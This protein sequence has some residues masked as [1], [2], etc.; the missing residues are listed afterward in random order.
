MAIVGTHQPYAAVPS[1]AATGASVDAAATAAAY[2]VL[3]GLFPNRANQYQAPYDEGLAKIPDG[4]A[5]TRG[6]AIGKDVA[7]RILA[8]RANDGRAVQLPAYVPGTAPGQFRGTNPINTYGPSSCSRAAPQKRGPLA[9]AFGGCRQG[10]EPAGEVFERRSVG[11]SS[12]VCCSHRRR[13]APPPATRR[14]RTP[15]NHG[16]TNRRGD[17]I[18]DAL[19]RK[20]SRGDRFRGDRHPDFA[21]L[22]VADFW[23]ARSYSAAMNC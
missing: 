16:R 17:E 3:A 19:R 18:E 2:W 10:G 9:R 23:P 7:T 6:I 21:A 14:R 4:E 1:I 5:K 15:R 22:E 20:P 11:A 12:R 13:R 8:L